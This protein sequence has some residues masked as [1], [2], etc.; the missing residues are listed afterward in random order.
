MTEGASSNSSSNKEHREDTKSSKHLRRDVTSSDSSKSS[1][2]N[3]KQHDKKR[4]REDYNH[5]SQGNR[6]KTN[7]FHKEKSRSPSRYSKHGN[8]P[9]SYLRNKH[10]EIK[11]SYYK[12]SAR[13]SFSNEFKEKRAHNSNTDESDR[14]K[15]LKEMMQNADWREEQRSN[16][17][18]KHREKES[19]EEAARISKH[20]PSF[21]RKELA[22]A[23]DSGT[24]EKRIQSNRHNIQR[25]VS[26]MNENFA[27]R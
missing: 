10:S 1:P 16:K 23:A 12:S 14:A 21:I 6:L 27:R 9:K 15:K 25:G 8:P 17:V 5:H 2:D 20:D 13:N 19:E 22:K 4:R 3:R 11:T 24:V 26:S 7:T 18:K